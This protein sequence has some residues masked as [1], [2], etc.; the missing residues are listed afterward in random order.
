MKQ[1][2]IDKSKG[3]FFYIQGLSGSGKTSIGKKLKK[4]IEKKY[5]P[6]LF[7][8][9]DNLRKIFKLYDYSYKGR[10]SNIEK[11]LKF[12]KFVT[13]QKINIILTVVGMMEKPRNWNKKNIKNYLEIYI[14]AD[15]K[16][17]I[18]FKKKNIYRKNKQRNIVGLSILPEF[19]KNPNIIIKNNFKD[20]IELLS[21]RLF[22]KIKFIIK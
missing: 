6:T 10:I 22:E 16:K 2:R 7:F 14:K 13:N 3:I 20:S 1:V 15:I 5:G 18:K 21:Q 4:N 9:G 17:I 8:N 19:P 11:F 12:S